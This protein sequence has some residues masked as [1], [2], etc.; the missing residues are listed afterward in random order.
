MQKTELNFFDEM[1][2]DVANSKEINVR[3]IYLGYQKWL[4]EI[5]RDLLDSKRQEAEVL[6]RR[7]GITVSY[8]HLDVYK[9]QQHVRVPKFN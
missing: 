4:K 1:Q 2:L 5:P 3:E 7:V 6:F 8:T 9:R